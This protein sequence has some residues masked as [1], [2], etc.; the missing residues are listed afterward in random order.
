V[1]ALPDTC[2]SPRELTIEEAGRLDITLSPDRASEFEAALGEQRERSR[3]T[4]TLAATARSTS[5][6]HAAGGT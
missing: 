5:P 3:A 1:F 4:T 2:G 6:G